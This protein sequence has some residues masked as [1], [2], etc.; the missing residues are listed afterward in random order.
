MKFEKAYENYINYINL[1]Q[2]PTSVIAFK[3]K[4]KNLILPHFKNKKINK[5][6][7]SDIV[8]WQQEIEK[9]G[10][11]YGYKRNLFYCLTAFFDYCI[12]Y[13]NLKKN[14]ARVVG[15]FK[16]NE[17]KQN[18]FKTWTINDY[19]NFINCVNDPVYKTLFKFLF[20]T[21]ARKSEALALTFN[22]I[23]FDNNIITI[24]KS[25]SKDLIEGK[26]II[27]PPKTKK[28]IR[29]IL[30]DKN[31]SEDLNNLQKHYINKFKNF[32]NNFFVF[33]GN[34]PMSCTTLS[35]KKD[36]YCEI[37]NVNKIRIHDFR[38]S[39]ATILFD[40]NVPVSTISKRLGHSSIK[41]T[42]DVYI[43]ASDDEISAVNVLNS[44]L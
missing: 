33:G 9:L 13:H 8:F 23:N 3:T 1:K 10:Y 15:N 7:E 41:T 17:I 21:G 29:N 4:F 37:A 36:Y 39:H 26:R 30:I 20:L 42:L 2:K 35:R 12:I 43:H 32:N 28:S 5:I 25:I 40:N 31:L 11:S 16:N 44:L 24:N 18:E 27:L 6:K 14:V 22:D 34:K 19:K 38:H